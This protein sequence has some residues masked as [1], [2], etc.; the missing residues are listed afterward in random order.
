MSLMS[1]SA[2]ATVDHV[3][4]SSILIYFEVRLGP[5]PLRCPSLTRLPKHDWA[6]LFFLLLKA[7]TQLTR[8]VQQE[9]IQVV[10]S[11]KVGRSRLAQRHPQSFTWSPGTRGISR[12]RIRAATSQFTTHIKFPSFEKFC[13]AEWKMQYYSQ[14]NCCTE[15]KQTFRKQNITINSDPLHSIEFCPPKF[16]SK[17]SKFP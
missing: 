6:F 10:C 15:H 17:T 4:F 12:I 11:N 16:F 7:A 1:R 13:M 9:R 14:V 2:G 5:E 8:Q 3:Q